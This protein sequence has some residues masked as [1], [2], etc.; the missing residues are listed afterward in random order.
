MDIQTNLRINGASTISYKEKSKITILNKILYDTI[1][2]ICDELANEFIGNSFSMELSHIDKITNKDAYEKLKLD[3]CDM[4]NYQGF[5]KYP[6]NGIKPDGGVILLNH[7]DNNYNIIET[8]IVFA[9]ELK[10]QGSNARRIAEG[11]PKQAIG[12]A[13]ERLGKNKDFIK[14]LSKDEA[15]FPYMI[16][17]S[18]CDTNEPFFLN[19]LVQYNNGRDTNTYNLYNRN[20]EASITFIIQ[21]DDFDEETFYNP[22]YRMIKDS[23][24]YFLNK[25]KMSER[26]NI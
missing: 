10:R 16:Y 14:T 12:N 20:G 2:G 17:V 25:K 21:E 18:G 11:K 1:D 22:A 24:L 8:N 15:I 6:N 3:H 4:S 23:L 26:Y 9:A 19:K 7:Y 5:I 13:I